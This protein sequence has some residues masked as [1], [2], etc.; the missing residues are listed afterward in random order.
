MRIGVAGTDSRQ[1]RAEVQFY[2]LPIE[3][4][5]MWPRKRQNVQLRSAASICFRQAPFG[6]LGPAMKASCHM[7]STW[8]ADAAA[9]GKRQEIA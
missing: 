8:T 4:R 2:S 6:A 7:R 1:F 5:V 3:L 9:R